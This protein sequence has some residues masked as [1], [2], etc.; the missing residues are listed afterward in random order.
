MYKNNNFNKK[1]QKLADEFTDPIYVGIDVDE[2]VI[3]DI[4]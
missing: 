3:D 1:F 2:H 4:K